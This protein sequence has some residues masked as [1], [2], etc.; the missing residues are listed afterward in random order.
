MIEEL[1]HFG[2]AIL[3]L[4]FDLP[5]LAGCLTGAGGWARNEGEAIFS[6]HSIPVHESQTP[7]FRG[8]HN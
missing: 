7:L 8:Q 4:L 2:K 1:G 6:L 3:P 5:L